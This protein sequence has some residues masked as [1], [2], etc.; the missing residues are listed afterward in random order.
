MHVFMIT[1]LIQDTYLLKEYT[2]EVFFGF[3]LLQ[4]YNE[5]FGI[6]AIPRQLNKGWNLDITDFALNLGIGNFCNLNTILK[7]LAP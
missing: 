2:W 3:R 7:I 6:W 4:G 5:A 1:F